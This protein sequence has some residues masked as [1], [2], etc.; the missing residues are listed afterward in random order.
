[1]FSS[2]TNSVLT[3]RA[4]QDAGVLGLQAVADLRVVD[5]VGELV[6]DVHHAVDPPAEGTGDGY[7]AA[8]LQLTPQR[9]NTLADLDVDT[10]WIDAQRVRQYVLADLGPDHLVRAD[11]HAHQ[12]V[13][14]DD[15]QQ[16]ALR[17][18]DRH[19]LDVARGEQPGRVGDVGAG[20]DRDGRC[21]HQFRGDLLA[22]PQPG[23][24]GATVPRPT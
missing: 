13:P 22:C 24:F 9:H 3:P 17:V 14:A 6:D 21:G 1:M 5:G 8:S 10:G 16:A 20:A 4:V 19:P 11:E 15:A 7:E 23:E 18:D 2:A 12:V